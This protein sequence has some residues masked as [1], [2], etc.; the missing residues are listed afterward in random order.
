MSTNAHINTGPRSCTFECL[1]GRRVCSAAL[2]LATLVCGRELQQHSGDVRLGSRPKVCVRTIMRFLQ[3][4]QC[5]DDLVLGCWHL[6]CAS[7]SISN[8]STGIRRLVSLRVEVEICCMC[9]ILTSLAVLCPTMLCCNMCMNAMG[10]ASTCMSRRIL[11]CSVRGR[12]AQTMHH[13]NVACAV[14]VQ[15]QF[16]VA[17]ILIRVI[18]GTTEDCLPLVVAHVHKTMAT[19]A[20]ISPSR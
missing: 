11:V 6:I 3:R 15:H 16:A 8:C 14:I 10:T 5:E 9:G 7:H 20:V 17:C 18:S 1:Y 13:S 4:S 19:Q 12:I 2:P